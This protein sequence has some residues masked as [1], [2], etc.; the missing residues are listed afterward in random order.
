MII[1]LILDRKDG[2]PYDANEFYNR[3]REYESEWDGM[4][5]E[6]SY[7]MDYGDDDDV[8]MAL[9]DYIRR[10]QYNPEIEDYIDS[11]EWICGEEC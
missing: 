1:D 6:I 3:I 11:V 9:C 10:N 5:D 8:R 7:A 4:H 2:V